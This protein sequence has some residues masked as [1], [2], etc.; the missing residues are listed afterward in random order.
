MKS[1]PSRLEAGEIKTHTYG[2]LYSINHALQEIAGHLKQL[3]DRR[4]LQPRFAESQRIALE[5]ARAGINRAVMDS[6]IGSELDDWAYFGKLKIV[7]ERAEEE[8]GP[9]PISCP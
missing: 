6:M 7:R 9:K 8:Q 3:E 2:S 4:V 5:E 1:D